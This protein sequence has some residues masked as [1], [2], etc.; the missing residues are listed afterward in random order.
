MR[1]WS[2]RFSDC[3]LKYLVSHGKQEISLNW[4]ISPTRMVIFRFLA[5]LMPLIYLQEPW[6]YWE[7]QAHAQQWV[8]ECFGRGKDSHALELSCTCLAHSQL[9]GCPA[10]VGGSSL[11]WGGKSMYDCTSMELLK[12]RLSGKLGAGHR[13]TP[14]TASCLPARDALNPAELSFLQKLMS[15]RRQCKLICT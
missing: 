15:S 10:S 2:R 14:C 5:F 9:F 12:V 13:D 6:F 3:L 11:G 7:L 4:V 8:E 1:F